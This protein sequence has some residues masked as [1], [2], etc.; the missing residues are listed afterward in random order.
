MPSPST[1]GTSSTTDYEELTYAAATV[2]G[3]PVSTPLVASRRLR[4][5]TSI[6]FSYDNLSR[7]TAKNL[8]GAE[9]DVTYGYDLLNR[10]TSAATSA[11]TLSFGF[12]A[13]G[14]NTS[15]A[16]PRGTVGY[17]YDAAGRRTSMTYPDSGLVV[18]YVYD[19]AGDSPRSARI[20]PAPTCCWRPMP[21]T[22][23]AGACR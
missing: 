17:A 7:L 20:R 14:R 10:M 3:N 6:A 18:G 21:G 4:D 1:A 5:A 11:Q 8:P 16:G 23:W 19:T 15:Q 9:L 22:I 13:L 12:D 2:G